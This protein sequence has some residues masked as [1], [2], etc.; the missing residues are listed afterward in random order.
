[1]GIWAFPL[2][3]EFIFQY[4]GGHEDGKAEGGWKIVYER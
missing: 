4:R 3:H 2:F 1:M